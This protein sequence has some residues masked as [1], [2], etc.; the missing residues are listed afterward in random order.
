M[1]T[2]HQRFSQWLDVKFNETE[3]TDLASAWCP[4]HSEAAKLHSKLVAKAWNLCDKYSELALALTE[5]NAP[6][7]VN[8]MSQIEQ[9]MDK[10]ALEAN[11]LLQGLKKCCA[12]PDHPQVFVLPTHQR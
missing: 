9:K 12:H 3:H 11:K 5:T 7:V 4:Q 2:T 10:V 1:K 8:R 6:K